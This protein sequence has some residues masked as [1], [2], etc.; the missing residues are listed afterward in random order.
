MSKQIKKG[1]VKTYAAALIGVEAR[2]IE[3]EADLR[4]GFIETTIVGLPDKAC[5]EAKQ[6]IRSSIRNS[7]YPLP[8]GLF[9]YNLAPADMP[10]SGPGFDLAMAIAMLVRQGEIRQSAV[11]KVLL[12]AE[13]SL[14]ARLRPVKGVLAAVQAA[15]EYGL[16]EVIVAHGNAREAALIKGLKVYPASDLKSVIEHLIAIKK[17]TPFPGSKAAAGPVSATDFADIRGHAFAK[18]ALEIAAAGGHHILMNGPPGSGKTMLAKALV[19]ILP[20]INS[21]EI[22][23]VTKIHSAAGLLSKDQ[24]Y[25]SQRPFRNPHHSASAASL[26]GGGNFPRPGEISLA[27]RG[28]LFLDELPE[29]PRYVLEN[30]RQPLE[31]GLISVARAKHTVEFPARFLL[32]A[33]MN[34]CPCGYSDDDE[35]QCICLPSLA[36]R[37]QQKLSGPLMDRFDLFIHVPR[38]KWQEFSNISSAE[39]SEIIR[40]RVSA[41]RAGQVSRQ[42]LSNQELSS[43]Q[44]SQ[45]VVLSSD[46]RHL[47]ESASKQLH[48]S[49]R[50]YYKILKLSRTI[51]DLEGLEKVETRH[52]AEAL[53]YRRQL[54]V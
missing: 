24:P 12:L 35:R 7:G 16:N 49:N 47:L 22:V 41:A 54:T 42:G 50:A 51:A 32:I 37:Y 46:S 21:Y 11:N 40:A 33:A 34:P 45:Y 1:A 9:I 26:V 17:I 27:H 15:K 30:L 38:I 28:V 44:V 48:L 8:R 36:R 10:K 3:V 14:D 5:S 53:Q 13:L 2:I 25:I 20:A 52:I 6:R 29:F 23:E 18:R 19:S 43:K 4:P 31:S 39:S